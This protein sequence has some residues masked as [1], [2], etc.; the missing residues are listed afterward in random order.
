M[1]ALKGRLELF[2]VNTKKLELFSANKMNWHVY[3]ARGKDNSLYTGIT[4]DLAR[5]LKEHNS[6]NR[7]GAKSLRPRR[8]VVLLYYQE[9]IN[10]SEAAKR[11]RAIKQWR[12]EYKLK[13]I[14]KF[15]LDNQ[16]S[17]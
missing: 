7:L 2:S 1:L 16:G 13:L 15:G 11:E 3:I 8:P 6:S 5:R 10:R 14:D 12:R 4:K 9:F 17:P